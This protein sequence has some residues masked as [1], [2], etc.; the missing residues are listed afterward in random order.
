MHS[1]RERAKQAEREVAKRK[2]SLRDIDGKLKRT[3]L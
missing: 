3:N 1:D 2:L